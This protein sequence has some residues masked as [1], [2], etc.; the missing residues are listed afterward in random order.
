MRVDLQG[1]RFEGSLE[2][3]LPRVLKPARYIGGEWGA[4][5][6]EPAEVDVRIALAFPD[7]Y[8]IGMSNLGLRI[9]YHALNQN[10]NVF[11]ERVFAPWPDMEQEMRAAGLPLF[12]LETLSPVSDFDVV[13]FS[14]SYELSYTNVLNM[15]DLAGIPQLSAERTDDDPIIIAGGHCTFNPEPMA[16]FI[17]AFVTGEGEEVVL[18]IADACKANRGN[19]KAILFALSQ[20]E[21]VYVPSFYEAEYSEDGRLVGIH[22]IRDGVPVTVSKRIVQ[23]FDAAIY[24]DRL[25]VPY[26]EAVHD[27]VVLEVMR[28][29]SRGCRFCQAGMITRPV[30]E[31]SKTLLMEQAETLTKDTGYDEIALTSLSSADYSEIHSLV[32]NLIDEYEPQRIG[33]S[34]PSLRADS[35]CVKLAAD[36][37][38]V[39]KSG[40]T[41]APEA[42]TQ[43]MRDVI[44]KNVS[45]DDLLGAVDAAV[46]HGWRKI[47]LYFM[48]GLP[49]ETD[50]DVLGITE[51]VRS[52]LT[53]ARELGKFVQLNVGVSSFVPKPQTPFQWRAQD[54]IAEVERKFQLLKDS[55]RMKNAA[56]S[57][58]DPKQ[59]RIEAV[60][61]RGD[62]RVGPAILENWKRG[63]NFDGWHEYFSYDRWMEAFKAAGIDPAYYA[64]RTRDYK[65]ALPWDHIDSG[66]SKRYLMVQDRLADKAETTPDC[67]EGVCTNCGIKAL[68][69]E[70]VENCWAAIKEQ[71][72]ETVEAPEAGPSAEVKQDGRHLVALTFSKGE[73]LRWLGHLDLLRTFERTIRRAGLP[74]SYS[75]GFNPRPRMRFASELGVGV[76]GAR[77]LLVIELSEPLDAVSIARSLNS[78]LPSGIRIV[79]VQILP[80]GAPKALHPVAS[81]YEV[82]VSGTTA[83]SLSKAVDRLL[84]SDEI[85]AVRKKDGKTRSLNIRPGIESIDVEPNGPVLVVQVT[86]GE[87]TPRVS[88]IMGALSEELPEV[89]PVQVHRSRLLLESDKTKVTNCK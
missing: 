33:V 65:E 81:V 56:L 2:K 26:L 13:G 8:E 63:G 41:F 36:I 73:R 11:A 45:L 23:D 53:R 15:L 28:G 47:K 42:G 17:D 64:N 76:T 75:E 7:V 3:I 37:Q 72:S 54:D 27:R 74:L 25:L 48:I 22:P 12:S 32:H 40:L 87:R 39:R 44:N 4:V 10:K 52:V 50:E 38:R 46:Q 86:H 6:K 85:V 58:H 60:L 35:E 16:D 20:I 55:M 5:S 43:R 88:E 61:A 51:V 9:L 49:T 62:R 1:C 34:L 57:W 14:L 71:K 21:G 19:R 24:P 67:R 80:E 31:K 78:S 89:E 82:Q 84:A 18:E 66:V 83:D 29:C 70:G 79:E 30:R 59:G 68:L 69:P 77:E